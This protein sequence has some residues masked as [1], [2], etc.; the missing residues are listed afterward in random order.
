MV[1][2]R[3]RVKYK[4]DPYSDHSLD[5]TKVSL[6]ARDLFEP[7]RNRKSGTAFWELPRAWLRLCD[8]SHGASCE[9][10]N[11]KSRL[12]KR[13]IDVKKQKLVESAELDGR[14]DQVRYLAFS[15]KWG[16]EWFA[17]TTAKNVETR[18]TRIPSKELPKNFADAIAVTK[19]LGCDYL[20]IDSLCINQRCEDDDG[21]FDEQA[22]DMR[23]IYSNAYCVIA[24]SSAN[25]AK[26]GFLDRSSELDAVRVGSVFV[27]AITNDFTRDVLESPLHRRGWV[28]QEHAL[29]HRTIFFTANQMYWECG[30]GVR[31]ETLRK[32]KQ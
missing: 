32:L 27:S 26:E 24:A 25:G 19:A 9:L 30:D 5:H 20:W 2:H 21:D 15:H 3:Y 12:P 8:S 29:A 13:L 23:T 17:V 28:L 14:Q 22:D 18:K 16:R 10:A 7:P 6:G 4:A 31:C 11:Q 1:S